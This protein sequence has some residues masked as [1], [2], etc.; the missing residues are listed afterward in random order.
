MRRNGTVIRNIASIRNSGRVRIARFA[1]HSRCARPAATPRLRRTHR[2]LFLFVATDPTACCHGPSALRTGWMKVLSRLVQTL[3]YLDVARAVSAA[4][5]G[6]PRSSC[7]HCVAAYSAP[8]RLRLESA[9]SSARR[10]ATANTCASDTAFG[11]GRRR[12][13]ARA[14]AP[15]VVVARARRIGR[16]NSQRPRASAAARR[17]PHRMRAVVPSASA[18]DAGACA[19]GRAPTT[20]EQRRR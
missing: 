13:R 15:P 4:R 1:R 17:W 8:S 20:R 9:P 18:A 14:G 5:I 10:A 12:H 19:A 6:T 16:A 2:P 7:G 11:I 3:G